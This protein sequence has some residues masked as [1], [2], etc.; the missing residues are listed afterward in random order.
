MPD[1][2]KGEPQ[3][4][5]EEV[6]TATLTAAVRAAGDQFL[7]MKETEGEKLIADILAH[8]SVIEKTVDEISVYAPAVVEKY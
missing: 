4:D 5:D 7:R 1:L 3:I 2:L 6:L 8:G